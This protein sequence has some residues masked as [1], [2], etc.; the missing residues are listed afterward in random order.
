[1]PSTAFWTLAVFAALCP[2][3]PLLRSEHRRRLWDWVGPVAAALLIPLLGFGLYFG[4]GTASAVALH[5]ALQN[6]TADPVALS[7]Q[8]V[9]YLHDYPEQSGFRLALAHLLRGQGRASEALDEIQ[10]LRDDYADE[11]VLL[12]LLADTYLD[13]QAPDRASEVLDDVLVLRPQ[14][15]RALLL[16][17]TVAMT[18]GRIGLAQDYW[19]RLVE[20]LP[21]DSQQ[22]ELIL[23]AV[24]KLNQER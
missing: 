3:V 16:A 4:Q 11:P 15:A 6:A 24:R 17:G 1:M 10:R 20:V 13:M 7:E 8:M 18:Q 12:L 21:Q 2:L 22:R 23:E 14:D 19:S 5:R 9:E